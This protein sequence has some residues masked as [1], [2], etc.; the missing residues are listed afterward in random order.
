MRKF[1]SILICI[2]LTFSLSACSNSNKAEN[3][4]ISNISDSSEYSDVIES[5]YMPMIEYALEKTYDYSIADLSTISYAFDAEY[6][7]TGPAENMVAVYDNGTEYIEDEIELFNAVCNLVIENM[8]N[9]VSTYDKYNY[10]ALFIDACTNYDSNA[11]A[12]IMSLTPYG[13]II[14]HES[15]C[16]GFSNTF[17]YLCELADLWCYSVSGKA[18]Y[19]GE[20]H[21]WNMVML[22]DGTYYVDVTWCDNKSSKSSWRNYFMV[23]QEELE[24]T[25]GDWEDVVATGLVDYS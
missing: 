15:V 12:G 24:K 10:L 2:S 3:L 17:L 13:C 25:H 19:N 23:T 18:L 20:T 16:L 21:G 6:A 4:A 9:D 11:S 8:P 22:E 5:V 7:Y 1:V 14:G